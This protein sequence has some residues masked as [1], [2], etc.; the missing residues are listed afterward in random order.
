MARPLKVYVITKNT[1][2]A[3]DRER[4]SMGAFSH[5]VS[6][7]TWDFAST[8]GK[9][10]TLDTRQ[11]KARGYDFVFHED[12]GSWGDYVGGALPVIYYSIDSTLSHDNHYLPRLQQGAKADLI[13]LDHDNRERFAS[14]GKPVRRWEYCVN[15][16]LFRDYG[17]PR[18]IDVNFHC[19]GGDEQRALVRQ[20]L[21]L[22]CAKNGLNFVSGVVDVDTYANHLARSKIT[23]N[24]PRNPANRPHRVYDA[25][26]C[27]SF[28]ITFPLP[29]RPLDEIKEGVLIPSTDYWDVET[30]D[31]LE[32]AIAEY[33]SGVYADK[34]DCGYEKVHDYHSWRVRAGELRAIVSEE[35]GI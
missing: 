22:I 32:A 35:F 13:L 6:E 17:L 4:R 8:L 19:G 33:F 23:V 29:E 7:F 14:A 15:T 12:G 24:V 1:P 28:L 5:P 10:F 18:D 31:G 30:I 3:V 16:K 27:R 11:L 2:R 25:L 34:N 26:A 20:Q 9:R 21:A